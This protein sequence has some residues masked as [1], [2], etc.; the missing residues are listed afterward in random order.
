MKSIRQNLIGMFVAWLA[1][2]FA[3]LAYAQS[4]I[5]T[6]APTTRASDEV[7][8]RIQR[9]LASVKTVQSDFIQEKKLTVFNRTMTIRGQLAL[10][11]PTRLLWTV[12]DPVKYAIRVEGDEVCQWDEDTNRVQVIHIGGDPTFRAIF[13]QFQAWFMGNY[14][15]VSQSYDVV[16]QSDRPP[17]SLSFTP[18]P[19]SAMA[20]I[21]QGVDLTFGSEESYISTL[22]VHEAGGDTTNIRFLNTQLNQPIKDEAW[23]IPPRAR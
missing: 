4:P 10:Q 19:G 23:E 2:G 8:S 13:E 14:S 3:A 12:S 22:V 16:V 1:I 18:K 15:S 17:V 9:Q 21:V 11:R 5:A 20:K 7:L 6:S